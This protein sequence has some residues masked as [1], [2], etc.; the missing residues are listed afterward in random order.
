MNEW[1]DGW[2]D[3]W[4]DGGTEGQRK[5]KQTGS[6]YRT[7][8]LATWSPKKACYCVLPLSCSFK[9]VNESIYISIL[10]H[11]EYNWKSK[12]NPLNVFFTHM[13]TIMGLKLP[14]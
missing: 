10:H 7:L 8:L 3:R 13:K 6:F 12:R 4:M 1:T 14:N 5:N 11:H 9:I 2:M